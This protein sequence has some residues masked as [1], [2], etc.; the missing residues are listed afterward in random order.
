[1]VQNYEEQQVVDG[2]EVRIERLDSNTD[3]NALAN[4]F[5]RDKEF[6]QLVHGRSI[7]R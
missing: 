5:I 4:H 6:M 3:N 7:P 1:M 2:G